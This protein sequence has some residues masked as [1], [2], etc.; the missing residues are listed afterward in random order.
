MAELNRPLRNANAVYY[1]YTNGP[2]SI[3]FYHIQTGP[4]IPLPHL[5][6]DRNGLNYLEDAICG[7]K[8]AT[9]LG[10]RV[11]TGRCR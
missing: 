8:G 11:R 5:I 6:S 2:R 7:S 10:K 4:G 3:L 9:G 1:R